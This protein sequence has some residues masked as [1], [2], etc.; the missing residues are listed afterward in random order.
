V[1]VAQA[2][3]DLSRGATAS[4]R[5]FSA[6]LRQLAA[7]WHHFHASNVRPFAARKYR[8]PPPWLHLEATAIHERGQT[9]LIRRTFNLKWQFRRLLQRLVLLK[10]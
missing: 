1:F 9:R 7:R 10:V 3:N 8:I 6:Y 4:T 2:H 5:R